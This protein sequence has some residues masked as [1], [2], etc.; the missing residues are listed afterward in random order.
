MTIS[1]RLLVGALLSIPA[2]LVSQSTASPLAGVWVSD[3]YGNVFEI[4]DDTMRTFQVT[5]LSC[6]PSFTAKVV[7]APPGALG[8]FR[9]LDAPVTFLVLRG[10]GPNQGRIHA[11]G[12]AS[13]MIVRRVDRKPAVC[14]HDAPNTP[15]SNFDVFATTWS[16]HY[17]FFALKGA[18]WPAIVA[19]NRAKVTDS[20]TPDQLFQ[21]FEGMI[22]PFHDAHTGISAEKIA[23]R[24]SGSR[25]TAGWVEPANRDK[26]FALVGAHL[27]GP[28]KPFCQG[29]LEFGM[30]GSDI[31]YLR[32]RGFG[33]YH[34]DGSFESGLTALE[35]ALDTVFAD[36]GHWR[37]FVIDVRING[38]GA[39]PYGL[40]IAARLT[41]Q[42]YIAYSKQARND[43][44]DPT[45]WTA[46][47]ISTVKPSARPGF[48]GPVAELIG[49]Q[50]VSAAE[51]ITQALMPRK[52]KVIRVG[53]HTQGVFSDVLG[54]QLP[55]GWRFWLPN[56]RFV[57]GDKTYDGPGI[58][59]DVEILSFTAEGLQ[60]GRDAGVER[61]VAILRR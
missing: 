9:L 38:G 11:N 19:A 18:D 49:I 21:I 12:A 35:A 58:P 48:K 1:A 55:N 28:L 46:P 13:D 3:G 33:R 32:I 51:T 36:A 44:A 52:P 41:D 5:T 30:L 10:S 20:T 29:Q 4:R 8:A 31:G 50:S 40:A 26:A 47:Q 27:A 37:G 6:L 15:H 56:E 60:S 45:K 22:T 24:Y 42:A 54:R 59:A 61:A 57:T 17:P 14:D 23:Q 7:P 25:R 16:E 43:P 34:P 53:E 2:P 39:D